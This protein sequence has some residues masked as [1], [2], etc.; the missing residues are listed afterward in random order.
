MS[1]GASFERD[2]LNTE[3]LHQAELHTLDTLYTPL[4]SRF[5]RITRLTRQALQVPV[6]A[7]AF[8]H[9]TRMWF[10]SIV[11]WNAAALAA[12]ESFCSWVVAADQA[13]FVEDT[14]AD[15]RFRQHPLV[16][17]PTG[18]RFYAG[19]PLRGIGEVTVGTL[20]VYDVRPREKT[21]LLVQTLRDVTALAQRELLT[22]DTRNPYA[23]LITRMGVARR[24]ASLDPV[25]R[26]LKYTA[27]LNLVATSRQHAGTQGEPLAICLAQI[28]EFGSLSAND[29]A[30][31][32]ELLGS[33]ASL[34]VGGVR[35]HDLVCRADGDAFLVIMPEMKPDHLRDV[36][37]RLCFR[38]SEFPLVTRSG[39]LTVTISLGAAVAQGPTADFQAL[40]TT[41]TRALAT[42]AGK[43][44]QSIAVAAPRV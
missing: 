3:T 29:P 23:A 5:D 33:V 27:G 2:Y 19:L 16:T 11:G 6:A 25:T 14:H 13:L 8:A 39:P 15:G 43:G 7:I 32:E 12:G 37:R 1:T 24:Q 9:D 35:A 21:Q 22:P 44:R 20:A 18:Y 34:L 42:C 30:F 17:G 10:K 28:D 40:M 26:L 41:A 4:E 38:V 31:G 36:A